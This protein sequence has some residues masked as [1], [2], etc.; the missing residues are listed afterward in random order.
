[1]SNPYLVTA[2]VLAA[3]LLGIREGLEL[4]PPSGP[5]PAEDDPRYAPLPW[6]VHEALDAFEASEPVRGMLGDEFCNIWS[7][8]RRY[9]LRRFEDHVTDWERTEYLEIY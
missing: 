3:G 6:T 8:V 1:M 9:E 5:G 7:A 4:E 2:G